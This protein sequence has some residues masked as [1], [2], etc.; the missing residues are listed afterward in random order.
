MARTA[1]SIALL[2]A[3]STKSRTMR[4]LVH[5][6]T[7]KLLYQGLTIPKRY[8]HCPEKNRIPL[9]KT[10]PS[11]H[12]SA[13]SL[14]AVNNSLSLRAA[15]P[16]KRKIRYCRSPEQTSDPKAKWET[17]EGAPDQTS[18][19]RANRVTAEEVLGLCS[20][21]RLSYQNPLLSFVWMSQRLPHR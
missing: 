18:G 20:Q 4:L 5:H 10:K 9:I 21:S 15:Q 13:S 11:P 7:N 2:L 1:P 12:S 14:I 8:D 17:A 6:A 3:V 19:P 16:V